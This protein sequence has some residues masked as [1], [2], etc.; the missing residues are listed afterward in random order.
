MRRARTITEKQSITFTVSINLCRF[1]TEE[2]CIKTPNAKL[3]IFVRQ[4]LSLFTII[5]KL[6]KNCCRKCVDSLPCGIY[7]NTS[8]EFKLNTCAKQNKIL[9]FAYYYIVF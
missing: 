2:F 6:K 1:S 8:R 9:F 4:P 7:N 5:N 3:C